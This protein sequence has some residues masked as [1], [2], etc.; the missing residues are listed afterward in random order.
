LVGGHLLASDIV[1]AIFINGIS[2]GNQVVDKHSNI[3]G[4]N[5]TQFGSLILKIN[6]NGVFIGLLNPL[7]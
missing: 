2:I 7:E 3:F 1:T 5:K 4:V 6:F